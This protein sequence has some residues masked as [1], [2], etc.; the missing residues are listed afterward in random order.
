[1][2]NNLF[3]L[4]GEDKKSIEFNLY[5]ILSKIDYD[6]NN[7]IIY[8][9]SVDKFMDVIEEAS[10][11]SLFSPIKVIIVNNFVIDDISLDE[12][13]YLGKYI[14]NNIKDVYIIFISNKVDTRKKNYKL[15]KDN[16]NVILLDELDSDSI[17]DYVSKNINDRGYKIDNFNIEYFISKVGNDINNINS[18]LEKLYIY[19]VDDKKINKED[20]DMLI[21][22]NIDNVIYEF[23]NAILD[24][25]YDKIKTMYDKFMLDNVGIDYLIATIYGSFRNCLIVKKMNNQ[26]IS[27]ME[28][29]KVIN[30]K[31]F[32]V[33]KTLDRLYRYSYDELCEYINKLAI[34]DRDIKSGKDNV[35]KFEL[36]LFSK[37]S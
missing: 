20:I 14:D 10:M 17:Y 27:N 8:D 29:A 18:E 36:F 25:D 16:F 32:F 30:K 9:M 31:E 22:D 24:N 4:V 21:F 26:N 13:N 33:K 5:N 15:F 23:T 37:E 2:K 19:K 7:K 34:I 12:L 11:V 3:L 35:G 28:I 1:M 6:E